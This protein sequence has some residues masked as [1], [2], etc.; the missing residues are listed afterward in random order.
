MWNTICRN[1]A[2]QSQPFQATWLFVRTS[3]HFRMRAASS[4][5]CHDSKSRGVLRLECKSAAF[6]MHPTSLWIR[7]LPEMKSQKN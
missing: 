1:R 7:A 2:E 3:E 5:V 4:N 6:I